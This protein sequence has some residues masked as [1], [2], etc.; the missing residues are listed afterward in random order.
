MRA[1]GMH[2]HRMPLFV[3]AM[4]VTAFMILFAMPAV[5]MA[6]TGLLL[7]RLVGTHFYN[8]AEGGDALLWQHLFW[9]FGHPEVYF[10]FVPALGFV[11][12]IIPTFARRPMFG[13]TAIVLALIATGFLSFGLWVHHMF[14]AQLPELG[15]SFFTAASMLIASPTA[16]QLFCWTATVWKGRIHFAVPMLY[17]IAFFVTLTLGGLTGIMVA[18]VPLDLQ[19]HDTYFV[20]AHLHYVLIGGAVFPLLGAW[21]YWYPKLT[22]R[23]LSERLGRWQFALIFIGFH[24]TFFPMHV[25]GLE[26]MPR[27]VYTYP[28]NLGWGT[29]NLVATLGGVMIALSVLLFIINVVRSRRH[30]MAAGPNPW[31]AGTLEWATASPPAAANFVAIPLVGARDPLWEPAGLRGRVGGLSIEDRE[32]IVTTVQDAAPDHRVAF[33]TPSVWPFVSAVAVTAMFL[34][35]VF[36]P[37]A[38]VWGSIPIAIAVTSWFWPSREETARHLAIEKQP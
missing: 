5:M 36:T 9:F 25:L 6:S 18:S 4:L 35:T 13:Y 15:K 38:L 2:M 14:A 29:L 17:I 23:M 21:Y 28:A 33:A 20:V 27:R 22:G 12:A 34:G 10:I 24:V 30:G 16:V 37:W 1:P 19:L 11:S 31:H 7:D 32:L 3:W 8:P 26:G